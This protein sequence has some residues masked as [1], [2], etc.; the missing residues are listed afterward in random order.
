[1]TLDGLN[2]PLVAWA[3]LESY[4]ATG[5]RA[6]L[7]R[8]WNPMVRYYGAL[9]KYLRQGNG[10]YMTGWASMDNSPMNACLAGGG[11]AVDTSA[12]MALFAR[13]LAEIAHLT[14]REREVN[15][16]LRDADEVSEQINRLMWDPA[17]GFY[18]DLRPDGTRCPVMTVAGYWTLLSRT[19]LGARAEA[20]VS[21]LSKPET[22]GRRHRV[23]SLA[24]SEDGYQA[25]GGYWRGSVWDPTNLMV[26]RGLEV[27][28]YAALASRI[29]LENLDAVAEVFANT[30]TLWEN[31]A[32]DAIAPGDP[33]K[34]DLVGWS[35]ITPILVL[36]EYKIG[37]K[38]D[39]ARNELRWSLAGPGRIGCERF[40]FN[41]HTVTLIADPAARAVGRWRIRV[42]SDGPFRLMARGANRRRV[43]SIRQGE[44]AFVL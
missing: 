23:P 2:H 26:I 16:F 10:L 35:G 18:F 21:Q 25:K 3:E 29:A 32:P 13:S 31:Y 43:I 34:K 9:R 41:G 1:V 7:Q 17:R 30:G 8:V 36:L 19:A 15:G 24:A 5:D 37:L 22:F 12:E 42:R 38:P 33:A 39:A 14:G 4:R 11:T 40:W 44:S 27:A 20:L 28:G 6:R